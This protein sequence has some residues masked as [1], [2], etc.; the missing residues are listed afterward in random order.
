MAREI[1]P[2]TIHPGQV[3]LARSSGSLNT[4]FMRTVVGNGVSVCIWD[5]VN[6]CGVMN[7]FMYPQ[8]GVTD[9]STDMFGDIS[10]Q[11]AIKLLERQGVA[12]K[13]MVAHIVGGSRSEDI[14]DKTGFQNISVARKVLQAHRIPIYSEDV[15]G[16]M[17]RKVV[18]NV[19]NGHI[20]VVKVYNLR[21]ADWGKREGSAK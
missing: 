3:Q 18:F 17:G 16:K 10:T 15:S 20:A 1:V 12:C 7:N 21:D 4:K 19:Q 9:S 14:W 8:K 2:I 6:K 13:D 11:K 5:S